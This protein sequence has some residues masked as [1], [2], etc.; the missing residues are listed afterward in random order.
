MSEAKPPLQPAETT[1]SA[2]RQEPAH[3]SAEFLVETAEGFHVLLRGEYLTPKDFPV[4][5]RNASKKLAEQGF[6]PVRRDVVI[7]MPSAPA[8][9]SS[10]AEAT[11]VKGENGAPPRCS[12]HGVGEYKEGTYKAD[13]AKAG[14]AYAFWACKTR[15][16]RPKGNPV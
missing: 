10:A 2:P 5:T 14:Q 1:V 13:H 8:A 6:K 11:W 15:G 12:V 16:C 7:E 4:W 9:A 3:Y